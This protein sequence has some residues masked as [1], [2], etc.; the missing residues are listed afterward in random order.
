MARQASLKIN[1]TI[2]S[3]GLL[4]LDRKKYMVGLRLIFLM[5]KINL[6]SLQ[7]FMMVDMYFLLDQ[8]LFYALIKMV[9][10]YLKVV[11]L[12]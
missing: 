9:I 6:V 5:K 2:Y 1:G 8:H 12:V 3:G 10:T 4:K 7:V 11:L